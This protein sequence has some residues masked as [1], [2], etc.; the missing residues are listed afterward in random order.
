MALRVATVDGSLREVKQAFLYDGASWRAISCSWVAN[1]AGGMVKEIDCVGAVNIS[2]EALDHQTLRV[3]WEAIGADLVHII[4]NGQEK[5]ASADPVGQTDVVG[6]V[7]GSTAT[8]WVEI[9]DSTGNFDSEHKEVVMPAMPA[10]AALYSSDRTNSSYVLNYSSVSGAT[11]YEI[12]NADNNAIWYGPGPALSVAHTGLATGGTYNDYV[13]SVHSSGVR[14]LAS[15][16]YSTTTTSAFP[17]GTYYFHPTS[18]HTWM[19][20]AQAYKPSTTELWH[21]DGSVFGASGGSRYTFFFGYQSDSNGMGIQQFFD[22]GGDVPV[23]VSGFS[24]HIA[25]MSKQHGVP[26]AQQ[27]RWFLHPFASKPVHPSPNTGAADIGTLALGEDKWIGL[28]FEWGAAL[29]KGE[30]QGMV[31]GGSAKYSSGAGYMIAP[32]NTGSNGCMGSIAI[33]VT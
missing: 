12:Y 33:T 26:S 5:L 15:G 19:D 21:G 1:T 7:P 16:V 20:G 28:Y 23:N 17:A 30:A 8:Y 27:C 24:C 10:P 4:V 6:V 32:Y 2:A 22:Q 13:K 9:D 29:A 31:W 11:A 18:A 3:Y 25:R 14:S